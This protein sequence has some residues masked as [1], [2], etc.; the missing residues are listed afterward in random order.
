MKSG[1][2]L[3]FQKLNNFAVHNAMHA[4]REHPIYTHT[5]LKL[6]VYQF[7]EQKILNP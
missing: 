6:R 4:C 3:P 1:F 5:N 2:L 7:K